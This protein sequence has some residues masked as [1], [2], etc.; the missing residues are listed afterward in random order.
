MRRW[1]VVLGFGGSVLA[2]ACDDETVEVVD[3][4]VCYSGM[5]W[6]G[7]KRGSPEMFPG[8]DCVGCHIDNDG[9]PLAFGGT[10]Y[11]YVLIPNSPG[12]LKQTGTDCFGLEGVEIVIED[13]DGQQF[14]VTTNRAGNFFVEG[15]PDDFA[16]P[17]GATITWTNPVNGNTQT[18]PMGTRPSYGGCANCHTPDTVAYTPE[19]D[20]E[21]PD[22]AVIP[23]ARIGLPGNGPGADG[24]ASIQDELNYLACADDPSV[25]QRIC[26]NLF[27]DYGRP[28]AVPR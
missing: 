25:N 20:I 17:F 14:V 23:T 16:K 1:M 28:T 15:N 22:L 5:R 10:I 12:L 8:R 4:E 21:T 24:F 7:D 2:F 9:P 26:D 11:P 27:E 18:T 19:P 6:V 13:N 3:K